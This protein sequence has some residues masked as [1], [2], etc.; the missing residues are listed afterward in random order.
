[1]PAAAISSQTEF[2]R[3]FLMARRSFVPQD[4]GVDMDREAFDDRAVEFFNSVYKGQF[5]ID[6]LLLHPAE[7]MRFCSDFR[8]M[9]GYFDLPDDIILRV[10]LQR[11]KNPGA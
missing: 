2:Y 9:Y 7:A 10:I 3:E 4:F 6:E 1:M 5:T 11:R 8:R